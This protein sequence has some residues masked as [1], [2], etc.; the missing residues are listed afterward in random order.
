[1]SSYGF[2]TLHVYAVSDKQGMEKVLAKCEELG[3]QTTGIF[4]CAPNGGQYLSVLPRDSKLGW[5]EVEEQR[6]K[7]YEVMS[8]CH[9]YNEECDGRDLHFTL[10]F[11]Y[12]HEQLDKWQSIIEISI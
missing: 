11:S 10:L 12:D 9:R 1:M 8:V 3:L 2:R 4:T 7:L 6:L 5:A